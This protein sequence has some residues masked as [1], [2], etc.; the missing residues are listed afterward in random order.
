MI[1]RIQPI[2]DA[3]REFRKFLAPDVPEFT[4]EHANDRTWSDEE[5]Q[6]FRNQSLYRDKRGVYLHFDADE[7]LLYVGMATTTF[8]RFWDSRGDDVRYTDIIPLEPPHDVLIPSLE[9]FLIRRLDPPHNTAGK[10]H[11]E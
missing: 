1:D 6:D 11:L 9:L 8:D 7:K 2:L 3:V 5:Y 10:V 4:I